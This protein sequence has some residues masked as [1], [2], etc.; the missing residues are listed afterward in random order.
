LKKN[1]VINLDKEIENIKKNKSRNIKITKNLVKNLNKKYQIS[2]IVLEK[3]I[4]DGLDT[5]EKV[6]Y[7]INRANI[8]IKKYHIN[9]IIWCCDPNKFV[10]NVIDYFKKKGLT[11]IGIQHGGGYL[12][13]EYSMH[14]IHSDFNFC[15]KFLTYGSSKYLKKKNFIE[16]GSLRAIFYRKYFNKN[17]NLNLTDKKILYVPNPILPDN[18]FTLNKP[19]HLKLDLQDKILNYLSN[20]NLKSII[21]LPQNPSADYYPLLLNKKNMKNFLIDHQKIF[22]SIIKHKPKII[23]LDYL[24][25]SIYECLYSKCEI[26]IFLDPYNRPKKDVL[27]ILTKRVHVVKNIEDLK[28]VVDKILN[29]KA[30]K[31]NGNFVKKF[32]SLKNSR[33][34]KEIFN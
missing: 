13:Q 19:S 24:A 31:L 32:Y 4:F 27:Q 20:T 7:L 5:M 34:L 12:L 33:K 2:K 9:K 28:N 10:A 29:K 30:T 15:D 23:I 26:I 21:K 22:K 1:I 14:H 18:L 25:T 6:S 11:V 8:L 3:I 16:V 17:K